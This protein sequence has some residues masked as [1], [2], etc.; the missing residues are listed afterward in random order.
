[1]SFDLSELYQDVVLDHGKKPRN[2]RRIEQ[3][4]RMA[5]GHNP[6]CG[7]HVIVY[8]NLDDGR[9]ADCSFQGAGCAICNASASLMT[10]SVR[11]QGAS[12]VTA[13]L[14]RFHDLLTNPSDPD[15]LEANVGKLAALAGV[16]RFPIRV[17]CATLPWHT[18][19]AALVKADEPVSTE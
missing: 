10:E 16:R 6:V 14:E 9:V 7:D 17:K 8:V 18:L 19:K 5:E 1:M 15:P 13:L 12:E 3:A 11:Q 2:F 4:D